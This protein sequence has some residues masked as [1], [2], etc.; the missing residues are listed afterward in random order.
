M[1]IHNRKLNEL[2]ALAADPEKM[3]RFEK[4]ALLTRRTSL[5]K[6]L[7][8]LTENDELIR[9]Q[10]KR[11]CE[12]HGVEPKVPRGTG[13]EDVHLKSL[14]PEKRYALSFLMGTLLG[15][16]D[17]GWA[18]NNAKLTNNNLVD[19]MVYSYR[20]YLQVFL[21]PIDQAP[22]N[23]EKFYYIYKKYEQNEIDMT[24]CQNCDSTF[25]DMRVMQDVKCPLCQ[26]HHHAEVKHAGS[27]QGSVRDAGFL[28]DS[29]RQ[30]RFAR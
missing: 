23:F 11:V 29:V 9:A 18:N 5:I 13:H 21:L 4:V 12:R 24:K 28:S 7:L 19:R 15:C 3:Y 25:I 22:V 6:T 1:T 10:I 27:G 20:R 26:T 17:G 2:S 16:G 8:G 14:G 30:L